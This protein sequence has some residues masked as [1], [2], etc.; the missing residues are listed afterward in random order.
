L[1]KALSEIENNSRIGHK[2]PELGEEIFCYPA[3]QH[4]IF[5]RLEGEIIY[6]LRVLHSK[7]N[8]AQ[9]LNQS[10]E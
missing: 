8:Y 6:V 9:H 3:G 7:M 4:Y 2:K 1:E 5:Y 10:I